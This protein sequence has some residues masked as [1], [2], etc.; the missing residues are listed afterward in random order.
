MAVVAI[1]RWPDP[2]LS[3]PCAPVAEGEDVS[4]LISD[5]FDTMY[6]AQGRG[7]AAPQIGVLKR[8]FVMDAGW[9]E[10]AP[11]PLALVNP[12]V[13]EVSPLR[14]TEVATEVCL[15]IA[16][17]EAPVLRSDAVRYAFLRD[18]ARRELAFEGV[19]AR[20]AQHEY[21]HLDGLVTFDRLDA[22][23]RD[24][25]EAPYLARIAEGQTS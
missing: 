7:L 16:G 11:Q 20:I 15:S 5:L 19:A 10:G 22:A 3:Q 24:R 17:V 8:V 25:L 13:L 18:G 2:C 1:R 9:K 21:D 14:G 23:L 6:A 4:G 12:E